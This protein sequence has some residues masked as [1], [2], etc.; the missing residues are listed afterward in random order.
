MIPWYDRRHQ[1]SHPHEV[2]HRIHLRLDCRVRYSSESA[3]QTL[4]N[5]PLDLVKVRMQ[6]RGETV[7]KTV[8]TKKMNFLQVFKQVYR[9][10]G[11]K[12]FFAGGQ[13]A[14]AR[15]LI[16]NGM[17]IGFYKVL[18]PGVAYCCSTSRTR[19]TGRTSGTPSSSACP[20]P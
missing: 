2:L 17:G 12:A 18:S 1:L 3:F 20:S 5:L 8:V 14:L 6:L 9:E 15:Q 4:V 7:S 16:C 19:S 13:T 10:E 11:L